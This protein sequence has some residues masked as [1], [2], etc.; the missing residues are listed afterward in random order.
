MSLPYFKNVLVSLHK[1]V[2]VSMKGKSSLASVGEAI[3]VSL[4]DE[5]SSL[6]V[7]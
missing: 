5:S 2:V 6:G 7:G 1:D 4:G 3:M